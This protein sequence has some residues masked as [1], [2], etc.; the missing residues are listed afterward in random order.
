MSVTIFL[1]NAFTLRVSF[2]Y[3]PA[4]VAAIKTVEDAAWDAASKTWRVPLIR[5]DALLR[6]FG[7]DC[8]V[9]PEVAMA[10]SPTLP[11]EHFALTCA[12]A[13]VTL[14]V[15][16][17]RVQGS[18]GC[19]TP[20]LQREIDARAVPLRRL[21]ES[22]WQPPRPLPPP[23]A[24]PVPASYDHI[25]DFDRHAAVWEQNW[26]ANEQRKQD[27]IDGAK[28]RKRKEM[29]RKFDAQLGIEGLI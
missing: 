17:E 22:G 6:V 7:D 11:I 16:G 1:H 13:G 29:I 5:L 26:L 19:W 14:T 9:A 18:G 15:Q 21:L 28:R 27:I 20:V 25:T 8:A 2:P 4:T 3:S 23:P 24:A 10:A 12:W